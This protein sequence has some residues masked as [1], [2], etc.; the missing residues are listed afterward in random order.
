MRVRLRGRVKPAAVVGVG[1]FL[2]VLAMAAPADAAAIINSALNAMLSLQVAPSGTNLWEADLL[3]G[4]PLQPNTYVSVYI[5][6]DLGCYYDA[7]GMFADGQRKIWRRIYLCG[8]GA[9]P[10]LTEF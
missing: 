10:R 5:K 1:A 9:A 7:R 6:G 3:K 2:A 4:H 8:P